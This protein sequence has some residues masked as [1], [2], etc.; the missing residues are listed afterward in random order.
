[1]SLR[2]GPSR[3][4]LPLIRWHVTH[5]P[6]PSTSALPRSALPGTVAFSEAMASERRNATSWPAW[7][8]E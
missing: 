7:G 8:F 4:P 3:E 6:L 1:M 2:S 5:C